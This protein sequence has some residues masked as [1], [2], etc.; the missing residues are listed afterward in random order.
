MADRGISPRTT[1]T[2]DLGSASK[3][4]RKL[5]LSDNGLAAMQNDF[6][7]DAGAHNSIYR[8]KEL[9][10]TWAELQ[11]KAQ[12][13][14][15]SDIYI[16]DYK[17]ITLTTNETVVCEVGGIETY[18]KSGSTAIGGCIDF[19]SRD[20]LAGGKRMNASNNNNGTAAEP[21]PWRASELFGTLNDETIGVYSTLPA[22][23]R[24]VIIEKRAYLEE[25]YSSGGLVS[26]DTGWSDAS[27]GKLWLPSEIEV[28]GHLVWSEPGFGTAGYGV[29]VQ[30]P[31]FRGD[32]KHIIKGDGNDG[33]RCNW[34][35]LSVYRLTSERFCI[36]SEAGIAGSSGAS[37]TSICVPLCF[38]I[39]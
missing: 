20:C 10:Y 32:M 30:Y 38:R 17:I 39:G 31:I 6:S 36:A 9:P 7:S 22:D 12:S 11:A 28:F 25:R 14:D 26:A 29:N 18:T 5:Y 4:W 37:S 13:H 2:V 33:S 27:L 35:E 23:L 15:Y 21:H 34:W 19:I 24:A 1:N 16:G 3:V 8:G